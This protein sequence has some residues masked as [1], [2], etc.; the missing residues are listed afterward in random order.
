MMNISVTLVWKKLLVQ[1]IFLSWQNMWLECQVP[2]TVL[3]HNLLAM[4]EIIKAV[5]VYDE[6]FQ[7]DSSQKLCS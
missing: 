3:W 4:I 6:L 1:F 2:K 5:D 7:K